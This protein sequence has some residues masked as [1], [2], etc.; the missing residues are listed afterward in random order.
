MVKLEYSCAGP[1]VYSGEQ[2]KRLEILPQSRAGLSHYQR[3][4]SVHTQ[5][6]SLFQLLSCLLCSADNRQL[7]NQRPK[8][9]Y[10]LRLRS[11]VKAGEQTIGKATS[12]AS[13]SQITEEEG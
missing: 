11:A 1:Y 8:R 7:A 4:M 6:T 9:E 10:R 3:R 2:M 13:G 5:A 12:T